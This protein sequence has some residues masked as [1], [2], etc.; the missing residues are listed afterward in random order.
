MNTRI[1][2]LAL[3]LACAVAAISFGA[4]L[5]VVISDRV[6]EA[7][8]AIVTIIQIAPDGSET[9][10]G[11]GFLISAD[12]LVVTN[13]HLV[14][15]A[16][17]LR[18]QL[19]GGDVY[20]Q[21]TL[22]AMDVVAD[23]AVIKIP[24]FNTPFVALSR[25]QSPVAG[26]AILVAHQS[27][28]VDKPIAP[29]SKALAQRTI[30]P[31]VELFSVETQFNAATKGC[32]VF[33]EQGNCLGIATLSYQ[34]EAGAGVVV[35][36]NR[37]LDLMAQNLNQ[38]LETVDWAKWKTDEDA[39]S[40]QRLASS[41]LRRRWPRPELWTEKRL[42]RRLEMA[43]EFDPTDLQTKTLQA[44][45]FIQERN[46]QR[47]A[48]RL[49]EVLVREPDS[50]PVLTLKGDLL[51]HTGDYDEARRVYQGIVERGY[52]APHNYDKEQRAI[53]LHRASHE[54]AIGECSGALGIGADELSFL[55]WGQDRFTIAYDKIK[56][57]AI[58]TT[59][60]SGQTVYE[61]NFYFV[62]PAIN[63]DKTWSKNEFQIRFAE[64]EIK[65][66]LLVH[67]RQRGV[68]TVET[69]KR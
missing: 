11:N 57:I 44:Q 27:K 39:P 40:S 9:L 2:A 19:S 1:N 16:A 59:L 33:D 52:Q 47:A 42:T 15:R 62:S 14:A 12:G 24:A 43:L 63:R 22:R 69:E 48:D 55:P 41:G 7:Q 18:I 37:I 17:K 49:A 68:E 28:P 8:K 36:V 46:Y 66:N 34:T 23:L 31:G 61:F 6:K 20:D 50:I 4:A 53:L 26:T 30:A 45:A 65:Q 10:R 58:K 13:A 29:Q 21:A 54:H 5:G 38:P 67:L 35:S 32:P 64:Q 3:L 56:K 25:L 60:R 51:Y